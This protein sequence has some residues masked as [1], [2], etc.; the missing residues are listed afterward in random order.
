MGDWADLLIILLGALP[1]FSVMIFFFA[2]QG[3]LKS[4]ATLAVAFAVMSLAAG[5][6]LDKIIIG[7]IYAAL[8]T[9]AGYFPLF[10]RRQLHRASENYRQS[11]TGMKEKLA[12]QKSDYE[13][14]MEKQR[15]LLKELEQITNRYAFAKTLISNTEENS[16]LSDFASIFSNE[17]RILG[18]AFSKHSDGAAEKK[19]GWS[20]AFISETVSEERWK[21]I[22]KNARL[23]ADAPSQTVL[24]E[25]GERQI[26]AI[27]SPLVELDDHESGLFPES[28][29]RSLVLISAPVTCSGSVQG[30]LT[31]LLNRTPPDHFTTEIPIYSQLLGLGLHKAALYRK[32][33]ERSRRD[34][35][36][37]LYLRRIFLERLNQEVSFSK[38]YGT[39]FSLLMCDLDRFKLVND[40]HGHPAGDV[41]LKKVAETLQATLQPGVTIC[42]YGGEEFA[43][44]IGLA[45]AHEVVQIAEKIRAAVASAK[46]ALSNGTKLKVT[47]S[48]GVAHYL[49]DAPSPQQLIQRSDEALYWAKE[50]GRN[51]VKEWKS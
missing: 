18:M 23:P 13:K 15:E 10:L 3:R 6:F 26:Q 51:C 41:V 40:T 16:I 8:F 5:F 39:S 22:L 42:R 7:V 21:Q 47:L 45:P 20:P 28:K 24:T 29:K 38:R 2:D 17:K 30:L 1:A 34:G 37:N 19:D 25:I 46:I 35:L 44:L 12:L 36:T 49:P 9:A 48:I 4:A 32:M 31:F 43:I 33:V 50:A 27:G 11:H 14:W